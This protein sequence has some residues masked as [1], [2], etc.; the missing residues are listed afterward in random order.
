MLLD[1]MSSHM[2]LDATLK[3]RLV[4]H[5]KRLMGALTKLVSMNIIYKLYE[6]FI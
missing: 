3:L 2:H 6:I 1:K 4:K 5:I